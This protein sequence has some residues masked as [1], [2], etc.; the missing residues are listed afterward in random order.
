MAELNERQSK[1]VGVADEQLN[2]DEIRRVLAN[3]LYRLV[4]YVTKGFLL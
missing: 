1:A 3:D 4:P 2:G